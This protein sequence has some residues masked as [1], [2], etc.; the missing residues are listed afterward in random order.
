MTSLE[1]LQHL[2]SSRK[3][4]NS[5]RTA[6]SIRSSSTALSLVVLTSSVLLN[7]LTPAELI[8]DLAALDALK[9]LKELNACGARLIASVLEREL[10]LARPHRD[11]LDGDESGGGTG[12]HDLVEGGDLFVLD[13]WWEKLLA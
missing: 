3:L 9:L 1:T 5:L 7:L 6:R 10:V 4:T 13:L 8:L 2:N 12:S 11:A